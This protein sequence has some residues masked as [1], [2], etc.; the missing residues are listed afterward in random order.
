MKTSKFILQVVLFSTIFFSVS[1]Y[2]QSITIGTQVWMTQNLNVDKFRNGDTIPQAPKMERNM[3][4]Y[5][6][7][8]R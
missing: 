8:M 1:V 5:T 4:S 6:I 2:A 7:G 3:V